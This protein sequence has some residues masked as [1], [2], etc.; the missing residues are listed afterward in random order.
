MLQ[1][2]MIDEFEIYKSELGRHEEK[3]KKKQWEFV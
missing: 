1:Q 2:V 3:P